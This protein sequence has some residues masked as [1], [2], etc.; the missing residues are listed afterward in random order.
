M[1]YR[2][3]FLK[4]RVTIGRG[5]GWG[6]VSGAR[7]RSPTRSIKNV[8]PRRSRLDCTDGR[9]FGSMRSDSSAALR[10]SRRRHRPMLLVQS[11]SARRQDHRSQDRGRSVTPPVMRARVIR[12]P[13]LISRHNVVRRRIRS[14]PSAGSAARRNLPVLLG[15]YASRQQMR[16]RVI[17]LLHPILRRSVRRISQRGLRQMKR[18]LRKIPLRTRRPM[19]IHPAIN[20]WGQR[21]TDGAVRQTLTC[22]CQRPM[23]RIEE[24]E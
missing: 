5:H 14:A 6:S 13:R 1:G 19:L 4:D 12:L 24:R 2:T 11:G 17:H 7:P 20:R 16:A 22:F 9:G 3:P 15:Q 10:A 8:R 21:E 18:R 23:V